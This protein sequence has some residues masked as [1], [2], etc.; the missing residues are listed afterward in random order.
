MTNPLKGVTFP[1]LPGEFQIPQ[2]AEDVGAR[3]DTWMPTAED[4]GALPAELSEVIANV[5]ADGAGAH[6]SIYRGKFLGNSVTAAQYAAINSGKFTELYIGDYWTIGG[7]IYRIAHFDYYLNCGDTACNTH[8]A[9]IIPDSCLYKAQMNT[10]NVTTGGYK[11]SAMYTANLAQ[12]R[13]TIG[14][15]FSGHVLS[16]RIYI[17]NATS[18]G[19]ASAGEWADSTVDLM[20]EQ[21]V[22]GTGIFSPVSDGSNVPSDYRVEKSQV[23]L[24]Q[25]DPSRITNRENW[26]LRDV[27]TAAYFAY[28][29]A[30]GFANYGAASNSYGVRPAFCIS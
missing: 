11:G 20:D 27:I 26:W 25:H 2:N 7:V 8:H 21:M 30:Y 6:N 4:V 1:G 14:A 29:Y 23:A 22:Y 16:H 28:V 9:V 15:A 10:S 3:P 5:T 19:R 13:T 24:F 17:T 12:A 18:G